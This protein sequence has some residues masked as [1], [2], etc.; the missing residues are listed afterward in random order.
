MAKKPATPENWTQ[1]GYWVS[2]QREALG[3]RQEDL[4]E[5]IGKDRQT[6]YRIEKGA[7]TKRATVVKIANAL[8][9]HPRTA[10]EIAFGLIS[11][12][13]QGSTLQSAETIEQTL[14]RAQAF[15]GRG[16]TEVEIVRLRPLMEVLDR[17]IDRLLQDK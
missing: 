17:E 12:E 13:P 4:A 2:E 14:R 11:Q 6:V 15:K 10:L 3:M 7:S 8:G 1:F 9:Q 5:K 16:L